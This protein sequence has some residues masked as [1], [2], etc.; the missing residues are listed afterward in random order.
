MIFPKLAKLSNYY[1][2]V[3][4]NR[5]VEISMGLEKISKDNKRGV[6]IRMSW[7]EK[8]KNGALYR[9]VRA[10]KRRFKKIF[11]KIN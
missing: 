10:K 6:G 3:P 5:G 4:Y 9:R 2:W 11:P 7:V 8:V 1:S